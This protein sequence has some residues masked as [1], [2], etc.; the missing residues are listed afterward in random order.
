MHGGVD[1]RRLQRGD[2]IPCRC[3]EVPRGVPGLLS[4]SGCDRK[5]VVSVRQIRIPN[6]LPITFQCWQTGYA[7]LQLTIPGTA[8]I[9]RVSC[10]ASTPV[11]SSTLNI[12][13][14]IMDF[15]EPIA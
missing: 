7:D 15:P 9:A 3:V 1:E 10:F 14:N 12:I 4:K 11:A 5:P 13:G 6:G 8:N 2:L